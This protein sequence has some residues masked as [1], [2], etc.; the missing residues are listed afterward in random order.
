[1]AS[2]E[3]N[4]IELLYII[5]SINHKNKQNMLLFPLIYN[6]FLIYFNCI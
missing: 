3:D 4:I 6:V 5:Q 1:M 2:G